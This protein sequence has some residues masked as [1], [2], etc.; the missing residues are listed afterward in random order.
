MQRTLVIITVDTEALAQ[1][2]MPIETDIYGRIGDEQFGVGRIMDLCESHGFPATFF[3]DTVEH[4]QFG[5]PAL[6]R[7]CRTIR[8]RGH[9]V[10]LH[11]HPNLAP[12]QRMRFMSQYSQAMQE[13]MIREGKELI[14]RWTGAAP[15]AFR[16][17]SYGANRATIRALKAAGIAMDSSYFAYHRNCTLSRELENAYTNRVFDIDGVREIPVTVYR[18]FNFGFYA[19][20]SK[21]DVNACSAEELRFAVDMF[22]GRTDVLIL[23]LHSFSFMRWNAGRT[24]LCPDRD[25]MAKFAQI[26][27]YIE[28]RPD[29]EVMT[30]A[31]YHERRIGGSPGETT[32]DECIPTSNFMLNISRLASRHR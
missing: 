18:L 22:A 31:R 6:E 12:G 3:V 19:D 7:L 27:D 16:A 26:L 4:H 23:F 10:Q 9:D 13:S 2:A 11:I 1:G 15:V 8:E 21:I 17:G 20:Y 32:P 14:T 30:M 28:C 29:L 25:T 5:R 24:S